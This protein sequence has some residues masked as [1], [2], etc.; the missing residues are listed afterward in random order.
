VPQ[1]VKDSVKKQSQAGEGGAAKTMC[2]PFDQLGFKLHA[3]P[4]GDQPLST[5]LRPKIARLVCLIR[6]CEVKYARICPIFCPVEP[7]F[8]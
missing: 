7:I 5:R 8:D 4:E 6:G 1:A 2:M 3:L